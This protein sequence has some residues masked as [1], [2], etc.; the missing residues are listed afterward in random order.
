M[1][2]QLFSEPPP[3][4]VQTLLTPKRKMIYGTI[5]FAPGT[6]L[7]MYL[8]SVKVE[9]DR[10]NA[11]LRD[12]HVESEIARQNARENK[13]LV[14]EQTIQEF[15]DRIRQ[16][17]AEVEAT[18]SA[19]AAQQT[20]SVESKSAAIAST[21]RP[22]KHTSVA[23]PKSAVQ[24]SAKKVAPRSEATV[25]TVDNDEE[26]SRPREP[27]LPAA[28]SDWEDTYQL[29]ATRLRGMRQRADAWLQSMT[30]ADTE[31]EAPP[32]RPTRPAT[33]G[34]GASGIAERVRSRERDQLERDVR[35]YREAQRKQS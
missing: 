28:L 5:A 17:E 34:Y 3:N 15:R 14:L 26:R 33:E 23:S 4:A 1:W 6:L 35:E 31:T 12:R 10:E 30:P 22:A 20:P 24:Q 29:W 16:L 8:Y 19:A 18:R 2:R 7:A 27:T 25:S 9:M 21:Q 13:D 11:V 32:T